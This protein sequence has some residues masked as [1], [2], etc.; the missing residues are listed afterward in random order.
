MKKVLPALLCGLAAACAAPPPPPRADGLLVAVAQPLTV[1]GDVAGNI[2]RMEPLVAEAARRGARLVLF[3]ECAVTGYDP[4]GAGAAA[5]VGLDH[6]ALRRIDAMAAAHGT[7]I[8]AGLYERR[9]GTLHNTSVAFL[10]GGRRV[11]QRKHLVMD[12]EKKAAPVVP[13]PRERAVFE[14]DG[15]RCAILICADAGIPGIFEEIARAGCDLAVLI[16]AGGGSTSMA[17]RQADLA[18]P[19]V[20]ADYAAKA[21]QCLSKEAIEQAIRLDLA[22][23]ACNQM[24]WVDATG[25]YH[26]GGSS[27]IDRTGEV[28]AVIPYRMILEHLGP[29]LAVG[30]VTRKAKSGP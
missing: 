28:T 25:Y 27:I 12:P 17:L 10:P 9:E 8:V 24:G 20:R 30:R 26:G 5:A 15:V 23:A 1:P 22:Q 29:Q 7:A 13:G 3:S 21:A 6:A 14:I 4:K 19:E 18:R 2:D 11:V 16:T